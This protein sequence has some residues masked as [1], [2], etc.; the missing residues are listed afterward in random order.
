MRGVPD[1]W[2]DVPGTRQRGEWISLAAA[3]ASHEPH[4]SKPDPES[5]RA[6]CGRIARGTAIGVRPTR[7]GPVPVPQPKRPYWTSATRLL[8]PSDL[9]RFLAISRHSEVISATFGNVR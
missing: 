5:T 9:H 7:E 2:R 6:A 1:G 4:G 8:P 3:F